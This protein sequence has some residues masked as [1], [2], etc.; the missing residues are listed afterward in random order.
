MARISPLLAAELTELP[1]PYCGRKVPAGL[2][3][4][5]AAQ[6][7]WGRCGV[8]LTHDGEVVGVLAMTPSEQRGQALVKVLWVRPELAGHGYGRQLVQAVAAEMVRLRLDALLAVGGRGR[9]SCASPP[10]RFLESVGFRQ[11][12][13]SRLWR[14]DLGQAV[15]ERSG[16]GI[17]GRLI[18]GLGAGPQPAG[19]TVS[20]RTS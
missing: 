9:Y 20:G 16:L 15:L 11:M 14:L 17:V 8:K 18:R 7:R 2:E 12:P 4:V 5:T 3:W 1:C 19:G 6:T 13:D 10:V